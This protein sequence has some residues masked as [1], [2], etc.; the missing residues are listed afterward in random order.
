MNFRNMDKQL[1]EYLL[2]VKKSKLKLLLFV[3][4]VSDLSDH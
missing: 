3:S 4:D 2:A 1:N